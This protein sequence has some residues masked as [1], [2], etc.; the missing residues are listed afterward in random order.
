MRRMFR[1]H[2]ED[3]YRRRLDQLGD[4]RACFY[5]LYRIHT[6]CLNINRSDLLNGAIGFF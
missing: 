3:F 2:G 1:L 4:Y 5:L 6:R